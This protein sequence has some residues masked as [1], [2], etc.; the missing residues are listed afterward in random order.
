MAPILKKSVAFPN[1][2]P[3]N[4]SALKSAMK[5]QRLNSNVETSNNKRQKLDQSTHSTRDQTIISVNPEVK[6]T[7]PTYDYRP[8]V[9]FH[10]VRHGEVSLTCFRVPLHPLPPFTKVQYVFI[11]TIISLGRTHCFPISVPGQEKRR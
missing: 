11:L 1:L 8:R 3:S 10:F 7:P 9:L 4:P 6:D 5:R 2:V